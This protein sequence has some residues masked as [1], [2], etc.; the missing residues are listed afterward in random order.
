MKTM[1][2]YCVSCKKNTAIANSGVTKAK[3]NRLM[4]LSNCTVYG[5]KS[6]SVKNQELSN[7]KFKMNKIINKRLL[8]GDTFMPELH[9]KQIGFTYSA[10][11]AFNKHCEKIQKFIETGSLKYLH[12]NELDKPCFAHDGA[13]SDSKDLAKRTISDQIKF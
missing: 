2:T 4:L 3:Q 1:E 7:Y 12:I 6:T 8:A 9:L 13:Y 11:G 10:C 5:K